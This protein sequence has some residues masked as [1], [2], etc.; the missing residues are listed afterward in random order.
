MK[1]G[2][3]YSFDASHPDAL[4]LYCSD[5]RFT[6]AVEALLRGLGYPRLDTLTIPGGPALLEMLSTD[7]SS[8]TALRKSLSFLVVAHKIKHVV[9]IA[10]EGCGYYRSRF[11]YESKEAIQKRQLSD[12]RSAEAWIQAR[13]PDAEVAT[14]YARTTR[15]VL[16]DGGHASRVHFERTE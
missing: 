3:G 7:H 15:S 1:A 16:P 13:H 2:E 6:D 4:A 11:S 12:L 8:L 10:H 9:L 5:G 14:Y